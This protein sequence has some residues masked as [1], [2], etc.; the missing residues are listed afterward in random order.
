MENDFGAVYKFRRCEDYSLIY[1]GI[2]QH[3]ANNIGLCDTLITWMLVVSWQRFT[4][5]PIPTPSY[6]P[7]SFEP[8]DYLFVSAYTFS[9]KESRLQMKNEVKWRLLQEMQRL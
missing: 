6:S 9:L 1:S 2:D 4:S 8:G 7:G 5:Y 3:L